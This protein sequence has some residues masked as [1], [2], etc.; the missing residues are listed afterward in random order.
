MR[1]KE[2]LRS[3]SVVKKDNYRRPNTKSTM[4][5]KDHTAAMNSDADS[6]KTN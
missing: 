2:A 3:I 6:L 5:N 4:A 1:E